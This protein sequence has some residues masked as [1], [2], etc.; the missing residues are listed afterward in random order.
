VTPSTLQLVG[1]VARLG[2]CEVARALPDGL[3]EVERALQ[4]RGKTEKR[5]Q[6]FCAGRIAAREAV[7]AAAPASGGFDV[8]AVDSGIDEGRPLIAP[9]RG[10]SISISHSGS[11]A[12]AAAAPGANLGIDLESAQLAPDASFASEAFAPGELEAWVL[13]TS[14]IPFRLAIAWAAKEAALKVWGVGLRAPLGAVGLVLERIAPAPLGFEL[15][16][17]LEVDRPLPQLGTAPLRLRGTLALVETWV[18]VV[19]EAA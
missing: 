15:W 7:R 18:L 5:R 14:L 17:R 13:P 1:R 10:V 12:V 8:V 3:S 2:W 11:W 16:L 4:A 6:E 19:L 9:P